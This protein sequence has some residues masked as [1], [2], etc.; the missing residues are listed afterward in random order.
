MALDPRKLQKQKERRSA[1]ARSRR[2][3]IRSKP[4]HS[5][6]ELLAQADRYPLQTCYVSESVFDQGIGYV[7]V[8]RQAPLGQVLAGLFLVDIYCLGVKVALAFLRSR[9][10]FD[11]EV[12][13]GALGDTTTLRPIEPAAARK[14]AEGAVDYADRHGLAPHNDYRSVRAIFG[15][16]DPDDC[17]QQFEYGK[18]GKPFFVSGPNDNEQRCRAIISKLTKACGPDGFDFLMPAF[19]EPW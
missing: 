6:H 15:Q 4:G 8:A 11:R 18:D 16:I 5:A 2:A 17:D 19:E 10:D 14:L 3:S 7:V 13:H 12:V 9:G 1:K